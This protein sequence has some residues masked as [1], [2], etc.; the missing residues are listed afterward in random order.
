MRLN[1][2][3]IGTEMKLNWPQLWCKN[4]SRAWKVHYIAEKSSIGHIHEEHRNH[5]NIHAVA[6]AK[7]EESGAMAWMF[8]MVFMIIMRQKRTGPYI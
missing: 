6:S 1:F 8:H 3:I 4:Q 2:D 7:K 5:V